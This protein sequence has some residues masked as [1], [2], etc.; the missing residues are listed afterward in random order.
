MLPR[1]ERFVQERKYLKNVSERTLEWHTQSLECL[2]IE[3]PTQDDLKDFVIR[4]RDSGLKASSCNC[5]IRSVNAYLH[6]N[7]RGS[8]VK[9]CPGCDHLRVAKL[10]EED[11]VP[12]TYSLKEI[13][14][15]ARWKAKGFYQRRLHALMLTLF[16]A[17]ARID[18][19]LSLR[20]QDCNLDDL[21]LTVTGKGRKQR[22]IPFSR[23]LRRVLAKFIL[24][25]CP[26][27]HQLIFGTKQGRKLA[28]N[29]VLRSVKRLC[30]RLGFK[31]PRRTVHATRHT[32]A[33][34]YLRRGGSLFHLQKMLGHTSLEMVRRYANLVTADLQA[35]HERVS[36][37][38]T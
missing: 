22:I 20:V 10:R 36:L 23:E 19:A 12:A 1:F 25:F 38:S 27:S 5:R 37:L 14:R 28:R 11:Y 31:A 32:F 21:L 16:D 7:S 29:N 24:E 30:M 34:E 13:S 8:D 4:M 9:C 6:W 15:I 35:V 17:G 2:G 18:E 3:R 26:L 33:T